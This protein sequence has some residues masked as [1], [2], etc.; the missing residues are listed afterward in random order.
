MASNYFVSNVAE[1]HLSHNCIYLKNN[2]NLERLNTVQPR[3]LCVNEK[4]K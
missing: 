4:M 3:Y 1:T 2:Y